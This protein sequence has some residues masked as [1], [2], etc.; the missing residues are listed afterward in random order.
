MSQTFGLFET[1]KRKD[2]VYMKFVHY[3]MK[4]SK[5]GEITYLKYT[6]YGDYY[7]FIQSKLSYKH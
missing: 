1:N 3:N 6:G 2:V 7:L 4:F 5:P